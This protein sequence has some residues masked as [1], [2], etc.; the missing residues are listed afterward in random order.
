MPQKYFKQAIKDLTY[1]T[2]SMII[3]TTKDGLSA[4]LNR[5]LNDPKK[6]VQDDYK[7]ST[8]TRTGATNTELQ[9]NTAIGQGIK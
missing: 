9:R 2:K 1:A 8:A 6:G 5:P 7:Y 3:K 4:K